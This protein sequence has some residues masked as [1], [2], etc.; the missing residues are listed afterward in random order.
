MPLT[1]VQR[2]RLGTARRPARGWVAAVNL[3]GIGMSAVLFLAGAAV[4]ELV[5]AGRVHFC[6]DRARRRR[7]PR[8]AG[9]RVDQVGTLCA[10]APLHTQPLAG[11]RHHAR[12]DGAAPL[13]ILADLACLAGG[14]GR[15]N[16]A[17]G[18]RRGWFPGGGRCRPRLLLR[19][20]GWRQAASEGPSPIV[21]RRR[22]ADAAVA[23]V[24]ATN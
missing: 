24:R 8:R 23:R 3:V 10:C 1:L 12:R 4:T 14:T 20:L 2:Y 5:G 17:G 6:P 18:N 13:R 21:R 16:V 7:R 9:P 11:T 15:W 19:L 22:A